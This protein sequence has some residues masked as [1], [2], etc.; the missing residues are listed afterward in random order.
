MLRDDSGGCIHGGTGAGAEEG[1]AV[2]RPN[3]DIPFSSG[4]TLSKGREPTEM[5]SEESGTVRAPSCG[6]AH[7]ARRSQGFG[8]NCCPFNYPHVSVNRAF[9]GRVTP[10]HRIQSRAGMGGS[11]A[12]RNPGFCSGSWPQ[13]VGCLVQRCA[14]PRR[15]EQL[16]Q[17][18][19]LA[20]GETAA[21]VQETHDPQIC[22]SS[23]GAF[24]SVLR[25]CAFWDQ[26]G[27]TCPAQ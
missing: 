24:R 15:P 14:L 13:R 19:G 18:L 10:E 12:D 4:V 22:P 16:R 25:S 11:G 27:R 20:G 23:L 6:G 9:S 21:Q 7:V 1:C 8:H 3:G 17:Q 26:R 2:W 5:C